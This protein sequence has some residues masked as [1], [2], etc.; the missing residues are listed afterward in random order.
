MMEKPQSW[1]Q[2]VAGMTP[3]IHQNLK[4]AVEL[5]KW[6]NGE[7]LSAEQKQHCLQAVIAYDQLYLPETD[8]T[9]FIDRSGLQKSQCDD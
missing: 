1:Q 5:G 6:P 4:T 7:R 3:E 8:R 9:A 2:L